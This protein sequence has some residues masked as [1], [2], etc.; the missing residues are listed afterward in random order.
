M[1]RATVTVFITTFFFPSMMYAQEVF[2]LSKGYVFNRGL[3]LSKGREQISLQNHFSRHLEDR[4]CN[5]S[6][7]VSKTLGASL[8]TNMER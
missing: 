3:L 6:N 2:P 1:Q 8:L 4:K 7:L 5:L